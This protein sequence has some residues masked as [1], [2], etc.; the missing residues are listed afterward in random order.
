MTVSFSRCFC[1]LCQNNG[2]K[3]NAAR[4]ER[5]PT[6]GGGALGGVAGGGACECASRV[7][8]SH[9]ADAQG[10]VDQ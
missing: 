8:D 1:F 2:R 6:L 3:K 9:G 5:K 7:A 4:H 10:R